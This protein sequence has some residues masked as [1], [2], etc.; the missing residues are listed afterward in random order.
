MKFQKVKDIN[1][2]PKVDPESGAMERGG[3]RVRRSVAHALWFLS[4]TR[5][6]LVVLVC[7]ALAYY[8]DT[9]RKAPFVLTGEQC[10]WIL[11]RSMSSGGYHQSSVIVI[12]SNWRATLR[13]RWAGSPG[14]IPWPHRKWALSNNI[15]SLLSPSE[16]FT[17][18]QT[19]SLI[20]RFKTRQCNCNSWVTEF[21]RQ[22]RIST[23]GDTFLWIPISVSVVCI[24][25]MSNTVESSHT[26][27]FLSV[28]V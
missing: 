12:F 9:Q 15:L 27:T 28:K 4:T 8:F 21:H 24:W 23:S 26:Q 13:Y 19:N 14:V 20:K 11:F 10:H 2:S 7:A 25:A 22:N 1:V 5:N 3:S 18:T 17:R 16:C 6:I